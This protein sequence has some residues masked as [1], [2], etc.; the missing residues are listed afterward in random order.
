M[1]DGTKYR[2][3]SAVTIPTDAATSAAPIDCPASVRGRA[4][5]D[6]PVGAFS[7]SDDPV[8]EGDC[9]ALIEQLLSAYSGS[10][11]SSGADAAN[12]RRPTGRP[13]GRAWLSARVCCNG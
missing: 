6:M 7:G 13:A 11:V 5:P 4:S 1:T 10:S 2:P 9:V 8:C 12:M 3:K